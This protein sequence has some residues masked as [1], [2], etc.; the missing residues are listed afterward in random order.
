[1]KLDA[2]TAT[3]VFSVITSIK[4]ILKSHPYSLRT[5]EHFVE[6]AKDKQESQ[7]TK[8]AK[9]YRDF[10]KKLHQFIGK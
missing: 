8:E 3:I 5:I 1:M 2:Y 4:E 7:N 6:V 9:M 10:A